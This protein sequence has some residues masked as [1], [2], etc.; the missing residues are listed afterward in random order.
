MCRRRLWCGWIRNALFDDR[1]EAGINDAL[2]GGDEFQVVDA[3]GCDD[4]A[5]GGVAEAIAH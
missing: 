3:G 5:V 1:H 4:G 2:I